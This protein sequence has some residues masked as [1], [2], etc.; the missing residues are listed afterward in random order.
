[1]NNAI[2][3]KHWKR[4]RAFD[5]GLDMFSCLWIAVYET[6]RC[7]VCREREQPCPGLVR[8]EVEIREDGKPGLITFD[9]CKSLIDCI[10][11]L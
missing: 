7:Y 10:K 4:F 3:P 11:G 1:M 2:I 5:Y 8:A 6:E 9:T